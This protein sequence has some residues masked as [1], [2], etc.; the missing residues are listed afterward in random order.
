LTAPVE[1]KRVLRALDTEKQRIDSSNHGALGPSAGFDIVKPR[2]VEYL[3]KWSDDVK[4]EVVSGKPPA[5][6][7]LYALMHFARDDLY[8]GTHHLRPGYL[9]MTGNAVHALNNYCCEELEKIGHITPGVKAEM[10]RATMNE[11]RNAG[12]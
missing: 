3:L 11:V 2:V 1:V 5:V 4:K 6:V 12:W 9:S 7:A 8:V 10:I